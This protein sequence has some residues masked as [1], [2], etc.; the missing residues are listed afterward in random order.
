MTAFTI[1]VAES[2]L[3]ADLKRLS[4]H[5]WILTETCWVGIEPTFNCT[6]TDSLKVAVSHA[7]LVTAAYYASVIYISTFLVAQRTVK[8]VLQP[9]SSNL[10]LPHTNPWISG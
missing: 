5:T 6:A 7:I 3:L 9:L 1:I 2:T 4:V 10:S 8:Q